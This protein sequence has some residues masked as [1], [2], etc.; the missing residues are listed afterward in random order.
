[1]KQIQDKK[2][3]LVVD[4]DKAFNTLVS[5]QLQDMGYEVS[6][7]LN[8]AQALQVLDRSE[9]DLTLLDIHLPD[10]NG[11][12]VL[13]QLSP[14]SPVIVLTAYGSVKTAVAAMK[15][16]AV[17]YLMK[18]VDLDEL[19]LT[20]QRALGVQE[21]K[22]DIEFVRSA[23]KTSARSF[24][25]GK[26]KALA[27]VDQLISLIAGEDV[28]VLI[29]GESGV[30]KELVAR[31]IHER[32]QRSQRNFVT[33]DCCTLQ[34]NLFESELFGH[35]RGAFTGADRQKKGLVEGAKGGTMF[36]DEL[37]E[38]GPVIQAKLLRFLETGEFRRLG[39]TKT[40]YSDARVLAATNRD[41]ET[42]SR[43]GEFRPDL[44]FRLNTFVIKVTPL[45]ERLEDIPDLV[46]HFL[47]NHDFSRRI[48]KKLSAEA[49]KALLNYDWPGNIRELRNV[50]ERAIILSG[51]EPLISKSHLGLTAG[52]SS[53]RHATELSF[54]HEPTLEEIKQR[55]LSDLLEKYHGQRARLSEVLGISERNLYR[56]IKKYDL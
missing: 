28:T 37:G 30:G 38:I 21:L 44:F 2:K 4:D 9:P 13:P 12:E 36:L 22:Q 7:A 41:L 11:L 19:E 6:S 40:L 14:V 33:L 16:G 34:E 29:T 32:S 47:S 49:S 3:I 52:H 48:N 8:W 55:Y 46:A 5:V 53:I 17:E 39:G 23:R 54:D 31:E 10:T 45:R 15:D 27:A 35:E 50:L 24:M 43:D 42:M 56:L 1:M 26:S 25:A 18:P 51:D 20:V